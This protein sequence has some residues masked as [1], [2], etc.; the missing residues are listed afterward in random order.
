MPPPRGAYKGASMAIKVKKR[1]KVDD[2]VMDKYRKYAELALENIYKKMQGMRPISRPA[3]LQKSRGDISRLNDI[4][5]GIS[6][7]G[8]GMDLEMSRLRSID[9]KAIYLEEIEGHDYLVGETEGLIITLKDYDYFEK[10]TGKKLKHY[11]YD[12]GDYKMYVWCGLL[13]TPK[14]SELHFIPQLDPF[15]SNRHYHHTGYSKEPNGRMPSHP[16]LM[17]P[18]SCWGGFASPLSVG[19][20]MVD[21]PELFRMMRVFVGRYNPGSPLS[22]PRFGRGQL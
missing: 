4:V 14:I 12:H 1:C 2:A 5:K 10:Q 18:N 15:N 17:R 3:Y 20:S 11:E 22:R 9:L 16:V 21:L 6:K 13:S 19:L 7:P 8:R